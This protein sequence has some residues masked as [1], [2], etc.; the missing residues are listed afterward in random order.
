MIR[1]AY[2]SVIHESVKNNC[3]TS[4]NIFFLIERSATTPMTLTQEA[5]VH[6]IFPGSFY[7]SSYPELQYSPYLK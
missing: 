6:I 3:R 4:V 2:A 5:V 1:T 7:F